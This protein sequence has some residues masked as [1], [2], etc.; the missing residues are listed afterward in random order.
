MKQLFISYSRKDI[1]FAKRLTES[2]AAQNM[3]AWVDWQDIPPSVDWMKEIQMGIERADIFLFIVSPDAIRSE[4][5][6]QEVSHAVLNG[7]RIIPVIAREFDSTNAPATITHLNWIFFSRPDDNYETAFEKLMTAVHTDYDWVQAHR[8]LQVK[9]LDW[10]KGQNETSYLLRGRELKDAEAQLLVNGQK[11]PHPTDL[12]REYISK[13]RDS[14]NTIIE[15]QQAKDQELALEKSMGKRL[16]QLTYLLLGVFTIAFLALYAWLYRVT[17]E[18][19]INS[20]KDQMIAIVETGAA[21]IDGDKFESLVNSYS[22]TNKA[23]YKDPYYSELNRQLE[24]MR[25]N[26]ANISTQVALYT[27][28]KSGQDDGVLIINSTVME[29]E[30]K[31][32]AYTGSPSRAHIA[33]FENTTADTNIVRDEMGSWISACTPILNS[34]NGSAGALCTDF[35][36]DY[37]RELRAEVANTLL[38]A[39]LVVYPAMI[40]LI[41]IT[42]RSALAQKLLGRF[43]KKHPPS[44]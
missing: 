22:K 33:G 10:V 39:F 23:V 44:P 42:T 4:V 41:L 9:A 7:K 32:L 3:E 6:A 12:Q 31:T 43:Y 15:L 26:N 14:E 30:F 24:T 16:R 27:I 21:F 20:L 35:N 25:G 34:G 17:S 5:C 8:R 2:F 40:V 29:I 1:E 11:S 36:A 18:L 28:T 13:S 37:L 38:I 19:A